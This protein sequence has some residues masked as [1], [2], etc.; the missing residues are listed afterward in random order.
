MVCGDEALSRFLLPAD[1]GGTHFENE[2]C[3]ARKAAHFSFSK[4]LP[5]LSAGNHFE[6]EKCAAFRAAHFHLISQISQTYE[7]TTTLPKQST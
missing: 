4:W 7:R 3:A 1:R 5:P 2:K 6:N